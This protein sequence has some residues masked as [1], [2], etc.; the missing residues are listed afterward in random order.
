MLEN[1]DS[2]EYFEPNMVSNWNCS[3][4]AEGY[5]ECETI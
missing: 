3:F 5:R 1:A 2:Q 4:L